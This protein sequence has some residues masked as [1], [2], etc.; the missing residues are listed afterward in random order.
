MNI[1][2]CIITR[3]EESNLPRCLESLRDIADEIVIVDSGSTDRTPFIATDFNARFIRHD[4]EGY[5]GQKNFALGKA[6][7]DWILSIDA[8]E[9]LSPELRDEIL[10]LKSTP[11]PDTTSG[12]SAPRVV[13]YQGTWIRFGDWYPDILIRLFRKDR[14]RFAGG[15]VHERLEIEGSVQPLGGELHHHSFKDEADYRARIDHYSNLWAQSARAEGKT[16]SA[17][18]PW[19]HA[20]VRFLRSYLLKGGFK[21]GALGLRL[22]R[23]QA[24]E[25]RLKYQKLRKDLNLHSFSHA[26]F[27]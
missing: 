6:S 22:A 12:Y 21:G 24:T 17:L 14:A 10:A 15:L 26:W 5:V 4:W 20:L 7:H 8:D 2:A 11:P 13:F 3:N 18:A 19:T 9:A 27:R 23:L 25:V 1:S 16:A